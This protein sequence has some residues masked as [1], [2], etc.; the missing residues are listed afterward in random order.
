MSLTT[1]DFPQA[2]RLEQV[3]KVAIAVANG[4]D[5]DIDIESFIGLDSFGRQG[6]YYR[7]AAE[8]L[9]LISTSQNH[10]H[11]TPLGVEYSSLN[12]DN[13]RID[14]L[15]RCVLETRVFQQAVAYI[16]KVNPNDSTLKAWFTSHYP[17]A[18]STAKRRFSTF[19]NYINYLVMH[20]VIKVTTGKY[21]LNRYTGAAI[22]RKVL[23]G[24][25][26][27]KREFKTY[28]TNNKTITVEIDA[29]K[30]ERANI[31]H[32]N[33]LTAKSEF[34]YDRKL[35]A[36]ENE[37]ID[38]Y[39]KDKEDIVIYEMKSMTEKNFISQL[40]KAISQLYEYRY[41]FS[42]PTAC[43][44]MVTNFPI[45]KKHEWAIN[46]LTKDREIAY[47]WTEDYKSFECHASSKSL[48]S[49]FAP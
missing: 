8:V 29:Q 7:H 42:A 17:G 20:K 11:L 35:P 48:L 38:L 4:N 6:R 39:S 45:P 21:V 13:A 2:D 3:G 37:L 9:G 41:I 1:G 12:S 22:K 19:M 44:C 34:L 49:Q 32:W 25:G 43:I 33:L 15:I 18:T 47:E 5:A 31:S 16:H 23:A 26:I 28:G 30:K 10:S 14:F 27:G 46:Y 36:I 40:R 24:N